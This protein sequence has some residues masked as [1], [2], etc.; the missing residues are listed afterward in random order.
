MTKALLERLNGV[1]RQPSNGKRFTV[2]RQKNSCRHVWTCGKL[3]ADREE[4]G[5]VAGAY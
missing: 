2:N 4:K 5:C 1:N 3:I